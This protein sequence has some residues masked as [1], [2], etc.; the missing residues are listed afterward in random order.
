MMSAGGASASPSCD[1]LDCAPYVARDVV[2][3]EAC[4]ERTRYIFGFDSSGGTLI[5]TGE[6]KWVQS[7][8]LVGV[9]FS[10]ASCDGI[11]GTAQS[12]DGAPLTCDGQAWRVDFTP[13]FM[14][15]T[16]RGEGILIS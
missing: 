2:A 1:G 8:P 14:P 9:R 15:E 12:P 5:C 13:V 11:K 7:V 6:G 4:V 10:G 16:A 3:G